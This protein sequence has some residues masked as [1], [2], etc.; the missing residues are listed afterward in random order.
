VTRGRLLDLVI[1]VV[2][3]SLMGSLTEAFVGIVRAASVDDRAAQLAVAIVFAA[4]FVL[5]VAAAVLKR[6]EF[7]Q[8]RHANDTGV[9][10]GCLCNPIFYFCLSLCIATVF[11][12]VFAAH[13]FGPKYVDRPGVFVPLLLCTLVLSTVQTVLVYRYFSPPKTPPSGWLRDPRAAL[14]GDVCVFLNTILFQ[15]LWSLVGRMQLPP[16]GGGADLAGRLFLIAFLSLLVYFPPR[17]FYLAE[18]A[19][20]PATWATML[21]ANAPT[22]ARIVWG[23]R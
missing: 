15:V 13:V 4:M 5:P 23:A 8:R 9:L 21:L 16:I 22:I 2:N 1:F 17:I 18:D 11:G 14:V 20:R 3:V 10:L 19:G 6:W 12:T 7:H